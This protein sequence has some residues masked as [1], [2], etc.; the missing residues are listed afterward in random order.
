M[1]KEPV[2]IK[3]NFPKIDEKKMRNFIFIGLGIV[4]LFLSIYTVEANENAV[5]L[6]FG[7]YHTTT[8][9]GLQFKIPFIDNVYKVRVDYQ[10]KK[11]FGFRTLQPNVR[12]QYKTRGY[13]V[14]SWILTG[15]LKIAEVKWV[16]Q[17]K[18]NDAKEYL[19]NVKNVENTIADVAEAAMQLMIGDRSFIEVLQQERVVIGD[20]AR[21]YMQNLLNEYEAGIS[22]QLVQLQG[23]VPP[24]PV[25]DSFNEVNRAKQEQET[26][27]NEAL[28][29]YN[30]KI[31][32]VEGDATR[33]ITEAEGYAIERINQ[34]NG[35]ANYYT[36]LYNE[37]KLYP[38]VTK[39]RMY[40]ETMDIVLSK[41]KNK[42]I[43][44]K[45]IENLVPFLNQNNL[46]LK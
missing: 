22:V 42:I 9:S 39:S 33:M 26:L 20:E 28:Q 27:I 45:D 23:V 19:F 18:I 21:K 2:D 14:E 36:S 35:D 32:K 17:Y 13:E 25:A 16:V 41:N 7:K 30:K 3:F 15:D 34:A 1:E 6:R 11:E 29:E 12:T 5:I 10:Y 31:Y 24:E 8:T 37:Y 44:D 40:I 4:I 38:D 43:I 46:K